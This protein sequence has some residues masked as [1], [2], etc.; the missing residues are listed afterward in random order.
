MRQSRNLHPVLLGLAVAAVGAGLSG[1]LARL[2][3]RSTAAS[4][5]AGRGR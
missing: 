3:A 4:R 1:A 5:P 2:T